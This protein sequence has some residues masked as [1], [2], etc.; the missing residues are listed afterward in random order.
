MAVRR[1]TEIGMDAALVSTVFPSNS[2]SASRPM[3]PARFRLLAQTAP[4][5]VYALGGVNPSNAGQVASFAGLAAID[6]LAQLS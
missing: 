4:L 5:P 3:G 1:A 6:G 2:P